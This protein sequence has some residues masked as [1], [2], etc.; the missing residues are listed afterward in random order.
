MIERGQRRPSAEITRLL[1]NKL[2]ADLFDYYE[3]LDCKKP[4][5]VREAIAQFNICRRL[6]DF[7]EL[8]KQSDKMRL[9]PDFKS[10]P[11]KYEIEVNH[12][13][14]L[15]F[16]EK[17]PQGAIDYIKK[18]LEEMDRKYYEEEFTANLF[19]VLSTCYQSLERIPE[20]KAALSS[21][22]K[23]LDNKRNIPKY[24][25][26]FVSS[27]L[28]TMT[29]AHL[30]EDYDLA[31]EQGLLINQFQLE[32]NTYERSNFTYFYMAFA[33]YKKNMIDQALDWF[34]KCLFDLLIHYSPM[35]LRIISNYGLFDKL[36]YH[37]GISPELRAKVKEK[38]D[39]I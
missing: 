38:Y 12:A 22:V 8:K 34:E 25:Q 3:Y 33:C 9:H 14:I 13:S 7:K 10:I 23:I 26:V 28:N 21:A 6:A 31:I 2:G 39:F 35:P 24:H 15:F 37:R 16:L 29:Y 30:S 27:K 11:W 19:L 1:G 4:I 36:F 18:T 5:E 20:A 32:T 17:N